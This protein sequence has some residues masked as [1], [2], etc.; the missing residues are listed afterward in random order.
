MGSKSRIAKHI[1][2]IILKDRKPDQ[3]YVE[4][5][6]GGGNMID[7]VGGLRLGV[8]LNENAI[9]ALTFIRNHPLPK[10]NLE[11][12]E[13]MYKEA[14]RRYRNKEY[15]HDV[16]CY[17]LFAFSFGA[18]WLGGWSRS[19]TNKGEDRDYVTEQYK[20]NM[21]Q[22]HLL[23]GVEFKQ[24]SYCDV[25]YP[26]GAIIYCDPPYANTTNYSNG[27]YHDI[28]W[29]WCRWM[30]E[31]GYAVFVSEYNAPDDF[32][33][34]WEGSLPVSFSKHASGKVAVEK[35]FKYNPNKKLA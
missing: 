32:E 26:E 4:P 19:K 18:K 10:N 13:D 29:Q 14:A 12:T 1:L 7:K 31:K 9:R 2:P 34:L 23:D 6:V 27:F 25:G 33:I 28:F 16:D 17:A 20:A 3:W 8:D 21:K 5:F 24:G 11:Y 22:K 30:S 15:I 35:L